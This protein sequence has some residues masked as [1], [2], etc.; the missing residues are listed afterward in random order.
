MAPKKFLANPAEIRKA[1][2]G[3]ATKAKSLDLAVAFIGPEWQRLLANYPGPIRAICWLTHP[4][5]DPDAVKSLMS[6]KSTFVKQ[7]NGLHT[8]VYLAP[9]VGAVVGSANLS[10]PALSDLVDSSQ[11]EAAVLV[12]EPKLIAEMSKWFGS[13]WNDH[14]YT[15]KITDLNLERARKERKKLPI[16]WPHTV[17]AVPPP[18]DALPQ[19]M[20]RLANEVKKIPLEKKFTRQRDQIR[21]LVSKQSLSAND[22]AKVA[23][24]LAGWTKHRA[25]YKNFEKHS[26]KKT[27]GGLRM[28]ADESRDI[29]DRLI[30]IEEKRLLKGLRI[31]TISLLLYWLRPDAYPPF[32]WKTERFLEDSKMNSPGMSASSPSCY[33]MW[34]G[35]AELLRAKLHLPTVGHVDRVVTKYYDGLKQ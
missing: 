1:I 31:P 24:T 18:P 5:T 7:R 3:L 9:A 20:I 27:L 16:R 10:R 13:L 30:E 14:L 12:L 25:V 29:Y 6:R 33:A 32:N 8:K 2:H 22:V 4:A 34:L 21:S 11:C 17:N 15:K 23:D 26:R 19:W 35:F 28:L